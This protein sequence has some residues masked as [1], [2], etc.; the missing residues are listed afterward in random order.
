M[1]RNDPEVDAVLSAAGLADL[2]GRFAEEDIDMSVLRMLG[3]EDLRELGLTLGQRKKL[4]G[5]LT[6]LAAYAGRGPQA[7]A[8]PEARRLG[9]GPAGRARRAARDGAALR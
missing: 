2:A 1:R 5:R 6:E 9:S 4:L 3:E 7:A 8:E